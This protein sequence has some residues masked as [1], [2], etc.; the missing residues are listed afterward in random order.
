MANAAG[1]RKTGWYHGWNIVAVCILAG[2]AASSLPVNGFSLFLVGW[3]RD[4]HVSFSTATLGITC[5]GLGCAVLSPFTGLATDRF[6]ARIILAGGVFGMALFYIGMSYVTHIWQY[7]ALYAV[8][9]PI[10]I[11][12]CTTI[13]ANAVVMRWFI[14]RLGLALGLTSMGLSVAGIVMPPIVAALLPHLGWRL[15]WRYAG[16]IIAVLVLPLI[17]LVI[18]EQPTEREGLHY[19]TADGAATAGHHGHGTAAGGASLRWLDIASRRNFWML[20]I[21]YL[22]ML[23]MYGGAG[24]NLTPIAASRNISVQLSAYLLSGWALAQMLATLG[25]GMLSDKFG[26]RLPLAAFAFLTAFGGVAVAFGQS[27][28]LLMLGALLVGIGGG[29]WP[30][31]A[32]ALAAEFGAAGFGRAFG[33]LL[34]FLPISSS[35]AFL[36]ARS[37]EVYGSYV[38]V[39]LAFTAMSIVGGIACLFMREKRGGHVA[40]Q[41]EARVERAVVSLP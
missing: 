18:R 31:I 14:K 6:P 17:L 10:S 19:I 7:L 34:L 40:P 12:A 16:I 13:P 39:L 30:L 5:F 3:S 25:G 4:L 23:I 29:F 37:K 41:E 24:Y 27:L 11:L 36:V 28:S 20:V 32:S 35:P 9:G 33:T 1:G 21:A 22:S 26:N 8:V 38:P 15:I 2:A